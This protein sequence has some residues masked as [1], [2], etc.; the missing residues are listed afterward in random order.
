MGPNAAPRVLVRTEIVGLPCAEPALEE[1]FLTRLDHV[2]Q[3]REH[4]LG[5]LRLRNEPINRLELVLGERA[6]SRQ[7]HVYEKTYYPLI[8]QPYRLFDGEL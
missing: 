2:M 3:A 8:M 7:Q 1:R 5:R 6:V 4:R